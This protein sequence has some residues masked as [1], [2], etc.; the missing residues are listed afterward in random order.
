MKYLLTFLAAGILFVGCKNE[1]KKDENVEVKTEDASEI[2]QNKTAADTA[3]ID[4]Q[5]ISHATAVINWG[6]ATFYL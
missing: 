6:E 4:I 2:A 5:P 1:S 3:S